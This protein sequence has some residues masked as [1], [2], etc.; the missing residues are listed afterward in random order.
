MRFDFLRL[1]TATKQFLQ[2]YRLMLLYLHLYY[3][4]TPVWNRI[5]PHLA[6]DIFLGTAFI[7]WFIRGVFPAESK[8]STLRFPT[9]CNSSA[10]APEHQSQRCRR[11]CHGKESRKSRSCRERKI[12]SSC[13]TPS[14][15]EAKK[16]VLCSLLD[17]FK[18]YTDHQTKDIAN[19]SSIYMTR[20]H[21]SKG[22]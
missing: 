6:V 22:V 16:E 17:E 21:S 18:C 7:D 4:C 9:I 2:L 13:G 8:S 5:A 20:L 15:L 1:R 19:D 3:L 11:K 12:Y 10:Q 14:C